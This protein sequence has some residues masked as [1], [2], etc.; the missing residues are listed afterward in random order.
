[1][2]K[3]KTNVYFLLCFYMCIDIISCQVVNLNINCN[4]ENFNVLTTRKI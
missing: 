4:I 3:K 2:K 1:M